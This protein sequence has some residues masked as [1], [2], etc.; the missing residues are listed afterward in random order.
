M[1]KKQLKCY[2]KFDKFR[3][4][5]TDNDSK[6]KYENYK[7][8]NKSDCET[9][10]DNY[11]GN[12]KSVDAG[13]K[14]K[15]CKKLFKDMK[16]QLKKDQF[17]KK[18]VIKIL[19]KL[20]EGIKNKFWKKDNISK[21]D[22][23]DED[24][25]LWG[26]PTSPRRLTQEKDAEFLEYKQDKGR[27][28]NLDNSS[29]VNSNFAPQ[30]PN[31]FIK[32]ED[33][34]SLKK[35]IHNPVGPSP[36]ERK[37][38]ETYYKNKAEFS[39][40]EKNMSH[41]QKKDFYRKLEM[42]NEFKQDTSD[43]SDD[44]QNSSADAEAKATQVLN[45]SADGVVAGNNQTVKHV[46]R[47]QGESVSQDGLTQTKYSTVD[48]KQSSNTNNSE[49]IRGVNT[50][51][52]GT[53]KF[54]Q[55]LTKLA[56]GEM[57]R[58]DT[59]EN[60]IVGA[61]AGQVMQVKNDAGAS[62]SNMKTLH[63]EKNSGESVSEDGLTT[64]NFKT[65]DI[66]QTE[67]AS[68]VENLTTVNTVQSKAGSVNSFGNSETEK[69]SQMRRLN[70]QLLAENLEVRVEEII[71]LDRLAK[72]SGIMFGYSE[73]SKVSLVGSD[74]F[75]GLDGFGIEAVKVKNLNALARLETV[76]K[77]SKMGSLIE[78]KIMGLGSKVVGAVVAAMA[79][80]LGML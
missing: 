17:F 24:R 26:A 64:T 4:Q 75:S 28:L 59:T 61:N 6:K 58:L 72:E 13:D 12:C 21:S 68:K 18:Q 31:M 30:S 66:S 16:A 53:D 29:M 47:N 74:N 8:K 25:R 35:Y 15:D 27:Q 78:E 54:S 41:Y 7:K 10:W 23:E 69:K 42:M 48:A 52:A 36:K 32:P 49:N 80:V 9:S 2:E 3:I 33:L 43:S 44:D 14:R 20:E 76:L 40:I 62:D 71:N 38:F 1:K 19:T 39:E 67:H 55:K 46:E 79:F 34:P 22:D 5:K 57:R 60:Q 50:L 11:V 63:V 51:A 70:R 56:S 65:E 45:A 77:E 73:I 37:L